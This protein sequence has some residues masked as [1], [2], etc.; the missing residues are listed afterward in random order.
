MEF[1][2]EI[3]SIFKPEGEGRSI[4]EETLKK[5]GILRGGADFPA[6]WGYPSEWEWGKR[7]QDRGSAHHPGKLACIQLG[8][9]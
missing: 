7:S 5:S 4:W 3:G 2:N 6:R 9:R 8:S 1:R